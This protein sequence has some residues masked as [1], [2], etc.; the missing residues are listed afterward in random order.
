MS[1]EETKVIFYKLSVGLRKYNLR[2]AGISNSRGSTAD[3][4]TL[5]IMDALDVYMDKVAASVSL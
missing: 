3:V 4:I 2:C 1:K 5:L